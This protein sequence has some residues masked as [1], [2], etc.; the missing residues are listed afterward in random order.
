MVD[1]SDVIS[2]FE[3]A[4]YRLTEPRRALAGLVAD[5]EGHFTA[6]DLLDTARRR[7]IGRAHV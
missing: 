3:E 2:A 6:D 5:R 7:Q 1:G 4:G